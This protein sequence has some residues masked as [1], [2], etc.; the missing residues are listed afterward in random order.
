M[1]LALSEH[2]TPIQI[3]PKLSLLRE[4]DCKRIWRNLDDRRVC[5]LCGHEFTGH[6]I[7]IRISHGR[8]QFCCPNTL[9]SGQ[10]PFFASGGN[11]LLNEN[12]WHDWM[13]DLEPATAASNTPEDLLSEAEPPP[14]ETTHPRDPDPDRPKA[15]SASNGYRTRGSRATAHASTRH[16]TS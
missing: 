13:R 4:Y 12:L 2:P 1:N 7:R 5:L 14:P 8:P 11:P 16:Q 10:L 15:A 9:C 3:H 6:A